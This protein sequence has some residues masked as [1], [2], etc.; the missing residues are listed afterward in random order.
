MAYPFG[1]GLSYTTFTQKLDS[2]TF[3]ATAHKYTATVTV[4]NNGDTYSG[5]NSVQLYV[6]SPY[7]QYDKDNLVEKASIQ[8][9]GF[10][11]T[12]LLA[13]GESKTLTIDVD[14]YLLASYDYK[15]F[16]SYI[17]GRR[18]LVFLLSV[19]IAMMR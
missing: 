18:R 8:L 16:Q 3:D 10:N 2:V 14:E 19:T 5:K 7:T 15:G 11:K 12:G 13:P 6:Q 17:L 9:V 1:Y 4:T